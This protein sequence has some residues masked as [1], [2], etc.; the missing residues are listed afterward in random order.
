MDDGGYPSKLAFTPSGAD[1]H[2]RG[3][4]SA[5]NRYT[6]KGSN[7]VESV[8]IGL[9]RMTSQLVLKKDNAIDLPF[10]N[11]C[12]DLEVA[13]AMAALNGGHREM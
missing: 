1:Q 5:G 9:V 10:D 2:F 6:V 11:S 7:P 12:G 3:F 8:D 13:A 4:W